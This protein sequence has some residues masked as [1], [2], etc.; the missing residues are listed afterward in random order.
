[1]ERD[2]KAKRNSKNGIQTCWVYFTL[3]VKLSPKSWY[4]AHISALLIF[5]YPD[6]S[7]GEKVNLSG[8]MPS[9]KIQNTFKCKSSFHS[10]R[11]STFLLLPWHLEC[12]QNLRFFFST[13]SPSLFF[14]N[15]LSQRTDTPDTHVLAWPL[16]PCRERKKKTS[17]T[18]SVEDSCGSAA[19]NMS[20][21]HSSGSLEGF[22]SSYFLFF[23]S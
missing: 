5:F 6:I 22:R 16:I 23:S 14:L 8:S 12:C 10:L 1:M 17:V 19:Q 2:K 18:K 20:V 11:C 15:N 7:M 21:F 3:A 4:P 9:T 13:P